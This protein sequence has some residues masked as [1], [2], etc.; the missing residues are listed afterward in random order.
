MTPPV[1]IPA[2]SRPPEALR[3]KR[4]S[5]GAARPPTASDASAKSPTVHREVTEEFLNEVAGELAKRLN[6]LVDALEKQG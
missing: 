5:R 4:S 3:S 6:A 1:S 2:T